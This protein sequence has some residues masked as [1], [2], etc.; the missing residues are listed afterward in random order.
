MAGGE[1]EGRGEKGEAKGYLGYTP[2]RLLP[3]HSLLVL[4]ERA[5]AVVVTG[6]AAA[7]AAAVASCLP[8]L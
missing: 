7:A 8:P 6:A 4:L 2:S 1:R 5:V 3:A